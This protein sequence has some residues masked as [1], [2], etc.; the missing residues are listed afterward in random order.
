MSQIGDKIISSLYNYIGEEKIDTI[1][2]TVAKELQ[3]KGPL[4]DKAI[5]IG[6]EVVLR[7]FMDCKRRKRSKE[8]VQ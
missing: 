3:G 6:E 5:E 1:V 7:L 2:E 8:H 4:V